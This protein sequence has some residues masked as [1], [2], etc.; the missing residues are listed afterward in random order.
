VER[1]VSIRVADNP[2]TYHLMFR[3]VVEPEEN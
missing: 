2:V 3:H 1:T